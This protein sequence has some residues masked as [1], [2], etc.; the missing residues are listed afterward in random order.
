VRP[1]RPWPALLCGPS[2]SP[3]EV[4]LN[5]AD[6]AARWTRYLASRGY[7]PRAHLIQQHFSSGKISRL[8][9][10]GCQSFDLAIA[11]DVPLE[12]LLPAS[13]RGGCALALSFHV[14][15]QPERDFVDIRIFVDARGYL[16]GIDVD[17]CANSSP[18]PE[19]V[20]LIEP[21][22]HIHGALSA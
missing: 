15:G 2:T 12:P 21:P 11:A 16:S 7:V 9:D 19:D 18:M 22:F 5:T 17:Y 4:M 8:C 13:E 20:A 6:T 14:A 3:L 1:R 10:C